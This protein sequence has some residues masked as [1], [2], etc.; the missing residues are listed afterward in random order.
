MATFW[1]D[2]A[3]F[4]S[5]KVIGPKFPRR[6]KLSVAWW[7][8]APRPAA[9][10]IFNQCQLDSSI[11][12]TS[13]AQHQPSSSQDRRRKVFW[14]MIDVWSAGCCWPGRGSGSGRHQLGCQHA[15]AA[16]RC[17]P[18]HPPDQSQPRPPAPPHL[19]QS[20]PSISPP[21]LNIL[22][23]AC[24]GTGRIHSILSLCIHWCHR[25]IELSRLCTSKKF[26]ITKT[27]YQKPPNVAQTEEL[28]ATVRK[29]RWQER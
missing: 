11:Q 3:K 20:Q 10:C 18:P 28:K 17:R 14:W 5:R 6:P 16:V 1:L 25:K 2:R 29:W 22:G 24:L 4:W 27:R 13:P 9:E 15:A 21:T 26:L 23:S 12:V 7:L 19:S 8:V